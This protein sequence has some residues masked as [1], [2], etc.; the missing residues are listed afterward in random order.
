V[1]F[2]TSAIPRAIDGLV[3]LCQAQT[4]T[5]GLLDG[6][7]IVDGPS[8]GQPYEELL[9]YIADSPVTG[10]AGA[11][12]TQEFV[13]MPA[14]ERDESF[15]IYC[16]A[17]SRTGA[18]MIKPQRDRAFATMAAVESLV[19][20]GYPGSDIT[21]GGAVSWCSVSGRIAYTPAQSEN[22]AVV[23]LAFEVVCRER[24]SGS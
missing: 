14:R 12:G 6:V 18:T 16:T 10:A 22:G 5:G 7:T 19:R 15:S 24:L 8:L 3:A 20:P 9:L 1:A 4:S 17:Y 21:L 11:L 13:T 23:R 2:E